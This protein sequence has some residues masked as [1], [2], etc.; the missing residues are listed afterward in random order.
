MLVWSGTHTLSRSILQ[1]SDTPAFAIGITFTRV[2]S[3]T[4]FALEEVKRALRL[5]FQLVL[6]QTRL[7]TV[8]IE[9]HQTKVHSGAPMCFSYRLGVRKY[10]RKTGQIIAKGHT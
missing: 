7:C 10:R 6:S 4:V 8:M 2:A 9:P 3:A 1:I 5:T